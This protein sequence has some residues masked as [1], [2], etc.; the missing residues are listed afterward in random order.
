MKVKKFDNGL[1]LIYTQ[2]D[3][4]FTNI[5][6]KFNVGSQ[7]E[8]DSTRG[9][10]HLLEHMVF[11]G[12]SKYTKEQINELIDE[13]GG[14]QN[15]CTAEYYTKYYGEVLSDYTENF[16]DILFDMCCKPNLTNEDF[17]KE[18]EIVIQELHD[19]ADNPWASLYDNHFYKNFDVFPIIGSEDIL[20]NM[21][22]RD[23]IDFYNK[24]YNYSN[25]IISVTT[26]LV[27]D[28]VEYAINGLIDEYS[29]FVGIKNTNERLI[30]NKSNHVVDINKN[31]DQSKLATSIIIPK[32]K[33]D[34]IEIFSEILG[35]S[36]SSRLFNVLREEKKLCYNV[37]SFL[38]S[39][40]NTDSCLVSI[41]YSDSDKTDE[42]L[43][44]IKT[45]VNNMANVTV[46]EFKR[47]VKACLSSIY[48]VSE[49]PSKI[50]N[51]V[52]SRYERNLPISTEDRIKQ[53][54]S[55]TYDDFVKFI[56]D[57]CVNKEFYTYI[58]K[59]K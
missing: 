44:V 18:K 4:Y 53:I 31:A 45:E 7:D 49:S 41:S 56:N 57:F 28:V 34:F 30:Y 55:I 25:L 12:S 42:I 26:P 35:G 39:Y 23:F 19:R 27:Y 40:Y 14:S 16:L 1:T 38:N 59:T 51:S 36:M 9:V 10:A 33:Y 20:N 13:F 32:E 15:A 47:G 48:R 58:I 50:N 6:F 46:G 43:D 21:T 3:S 37:S 5:S 22:H 2:K 54:K 52:I 24:Y 11:N 17:I 29:H 8:S